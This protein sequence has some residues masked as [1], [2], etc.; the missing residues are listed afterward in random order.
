VRGV[1]YGTDGCHLAGR[2]GIPTVVLGPGHIAQAHSAAEW[3]D[4]AQ[5]ADA[6]AIYMRIVMEVAA[7]HAA[8]AARR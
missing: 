6:A 7:Q 1:A 2:A 5:V 8:D 3:V 4:L